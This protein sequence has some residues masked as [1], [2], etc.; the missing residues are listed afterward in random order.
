MQ[1]QEQ[2]VAPALAEQ[3]DPNESTRR[4]RSGSS[5]RWYRLMLRN[6]KAA[7]GLFVIVSFITIAIL[8]PVISPGDPQNFVDRPHL[9]PSRAHWFGTTGRGQDVFDQTVWGARQ[10]L[11]VGL[12]VGLTVTL[13]GIVIGMSAGYF[14]GRIDDVLSVIMNVFLIIPA[15]PLLV[16][17][18][19]I[20]RAGSMQFYVFVLTL[21]GWAWGARVFR[22]QVLS[23]R[24]KDYVA[25][26][27]VSGEG[28]LRIIFSEILPNMTS[29]VVAN[30]LGATIYA[31]G[32]QAG[33]E[34]LGLGNPN[35]VSWG[36]NL[37]WAANDAALIVGAWW[38]FVPAGVGIALVAFSF[39][40]MNYAIDEITNPRL[41][42]QREIGSVLK[43][44]SIR[45]SS[46]R[47]T[48]VLRHQ[49]S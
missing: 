33:L 20:I 12:I 13:V 5:S 28:N 39:A 16:V 46:T 30:L 40:M 8:A 3:A 44:R 34:F 15:L 41:R 22:S 10:T 49:S 38:T 25:A 42:S 27:K 19:A 9:A 45:V 31:I 43:K 47:A 1:V 24:E 23:L 21:T 7:F 11:E 18:S 14:G 29:I 2:A 32:F 35:V 36:T 26:A 6:R 37:Y 48:P 4:T 17:L